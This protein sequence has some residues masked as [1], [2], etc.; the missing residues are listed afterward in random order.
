MV[1][2]NLRIDVWRIDQDPD[3][4]VG[5]A[6]LTGTLLYSGVQARLEDEAAPL[7]LQAQGLETTHIYNCMVRP[8]TLDIHEN[9]EVKVVTGDYLKFLAIA[10]DEDNDELT[11]SVHDNFGNILSIANPIN[12]QCLF[13]W[14][15]P[16]N[17]G[18]YEL[19]VI[20]DDGNGGGDKVVIHITVYTEEADIL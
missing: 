4:Y 13:D 8:T 16:N 12:T 2:F 6:M 5:G 17:P 1:G 14:L 15:A 19:T 11:Y 18:S 20:V 10:S 9:D 7:I 3:D